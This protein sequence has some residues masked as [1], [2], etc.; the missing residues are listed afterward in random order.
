M[1]PFLVSK[2]PVH[3]HVVVALAMIDEII[4][5]AIEMP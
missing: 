2:G 1:L 5:A 4:T 3:Q